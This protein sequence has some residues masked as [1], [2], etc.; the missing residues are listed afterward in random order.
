MNELSLNVKSLGKQLSK[1]VRFAVL[2]E[3]DAKMLLE[4][5]HQALPSTK[6]P[7]VRIRQRHHL[8]ARLLALGLEPVQ[9][10][11]QTGYAPS[12]VAE[13]QADPSFRE[14]LSFYSKEVA[15]ATAD[16]TVRLEG[17]SM[18][19]LNVIQERLE[20]N[21]DEISTKDLIEL[22]K[23]T[24]DRTGH[25]PSSSH[26]V[27][28]SGNLSLEAVAKIKGAALDEGRAQV[29]D[30]EDY[31]ELGV[32][33]PAQLEAGAHSGAEAARGVLEGEAVREPGGEAIDDGAAGTRTDEEPASAESVVPLHGS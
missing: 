14:L 5:E 32:G 10:S 1:P 13:L 11:L 23:T 18:E 22:I 17:L 21:P 19:A 33:E 29:I 16:V 12:R 6:A 9:V 25:G 24:A 27:N 20:N 8:C 15:E 2:G 26:S 4:R 31:R 3:V 28:V 7:L 30:S